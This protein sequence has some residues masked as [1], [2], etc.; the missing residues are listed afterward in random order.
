MPFYRIYPLS[1]AGRVCPP[2]DA[3]CSDDTAAL[4]AASG[5]DAQVAH[6]CEVWELTR[7]LGRFHFAAARNPAVE[8]AKTAR[9]VQA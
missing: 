7:F 1:R 9:G 2:I 8:A 6:G 4:A 3:E 5:L